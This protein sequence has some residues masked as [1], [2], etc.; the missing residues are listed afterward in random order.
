MLAFYC[1][2]FRCSFLSRSWSLSETCSD[3]LSLAQ[4]NL[5]FNQLCGL[6]NNGEGTYTL[7]SHVRWC[8][9]AVFGLLQVSI[10]VHSSSEG[11]GSVRTARAGLGAVCA[12]SSSWR[13]R[14]R[15]GPLRD[16]D[17]P[18]SRQAS[19]TAAELRNNF[20]DDAAKQMLR[21]S[22]KERAGFQLEL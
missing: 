17:R 15:R 10:P 12:D 4:I 1:S 13:G 20:L 11:S 21:E 19:L 5:S 16:D 9:A 3:R 18:L 14:L 8:V 7:L 22:V 2:L 6:D